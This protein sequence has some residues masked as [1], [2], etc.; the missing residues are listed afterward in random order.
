Q[1][2]L[3]FAYGVEERTTEHFLKEAC[4]SAHRIKKL[5]PDTNITLVTNPGLP[6]DMEDVEGAF[7]LIMHVDEEDLLPGQV[8]SWTPNGLARQWLTRLEYLSRSPYKVTLALDSQALCCASGVNNIL[9]EGPGEFDIA[10]AVQGPKLLTPHNWALMYR[11][12]DN[13][14]R[15]FNRWRMIHIAK[16]RVGSDQGTLHVAAGS[17]ALQD[18]LKVGV[19]AETVAMAT[20]PYNHSAPAWP[21]SSPLLEPGPVHFVHYNAFTH[22]EED[23]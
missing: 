18:K 2:I 21:R 5:N 6:P 1:G 17:L 11:L 22:E 9:S 7:D 4:F 14:R 3:F 15:L 12:N 13:T 23:M 20:V 10:F 19:L 8:P 16:S